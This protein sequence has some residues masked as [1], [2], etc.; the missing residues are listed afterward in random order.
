M[1]PALI[2]LLVTILRLVGELLGWSESLF[3]R[4]A[5]GSA[6]LIGI[7][8]LVPIFGIYFGWK[9][10]KSGRIP[11]DTKRAIGLLFLILLVLTAEAVQTNAGGLPVQATLLLTAI[12]SIA[13]IYFS[14]YTWPD[15][16]KVL[17]AYGLA[18]RIPVVVVM[19]IAIY[20]NWGTHYD[21]APPNF[22]ET[23]GPFLK[24]VLIGLLPQMTAWIAFTL[25]LGGI[26]GTVTAALVKQK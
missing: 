1:V 14:F 20:A 7:V 22:P 3:G 9:L 25:I 19:L 16:A 8:W 26:F 2:T 11:T 4:S 23:I 24:W 17:F 15:L 13:A 18:A 6:S 10:V 5:G 12:Y 21:V